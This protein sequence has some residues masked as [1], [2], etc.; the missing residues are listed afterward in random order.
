M[1]SASTPGFFIPRPLPGG[2][3]DHLLADEAH[4]VLLAGVRLGLL[5][6]LG[7]AEQGDDARRALGDADALTVGEADQRRV[8]GGLVGG[9][10]PHDD[11]HA[12]QVGR[13]LE[14]I[15]LERE[16]LQVV[17]LGEHAPVEVVTLALIDDFGLGPDDS[18]VATEQIL[19]GEVVQVRL[20]RRPRGLD[21]QASV[22]RQAVASGGHLVRERV[23]LGVHVRDGLGDGLDGLPRAG[24]RGQASLGQTGQGRDLVVDRAGR[25]PVQLIVEVA[26]ATAELADVGRQR[27]DLLRVHPPAVFGVLAVERGR[28]LEHLLELGRVDVGD[29]LADLGEL[30]R[31]LATGLDLGRV[32]VS[33]QADA[34]GHGE[35]GGRGGE[36]DLAQDGLVQGVSPS[37]LS[38][39]VASE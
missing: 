28:Q 17:R 15:P 2:D 5:H 25:E 11:V 7:L 35:Q 16:P 33:P 39:S 19:H 34:Q 29:A 3:D 13:D 8:A 4:A 23:G 12:E 26:E 38:V 9:E 31:G 37:S 14:S 1:W 22:G 18:H 36:H 30:L 6:A 32:G 21:Q 20:V 10:V 27:V 24:H